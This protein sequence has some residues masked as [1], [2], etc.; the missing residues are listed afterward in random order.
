MKTSWAK[1]TACSSGRL[2]RRFT[3][4]DSSSL[5]AASAI[6]TIVSASL[7]V[8]SR[9]V[10]ERSWPRF[11]RAWCSSR[12]RMKSLIPTGRDY[13]GS[14]ARLQEDLPRH[15]AGALLAGA[16][17]GAPAG[18]APQEQGH[19]CRLL[20]RAVGPLHA[21]LSCGLLPR[22]LQDAVE[23]VGKDAGP[24]VAH[25]RSLDERPVDHGRTERKEG[26]S[27]GVRHAFFQVCSYE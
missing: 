25:E 7:R 1:R 27:E 17:F 9:S 5:M 26:Y 22:S 8:S 4:T 14:G 10:S 18:S 21:G 3:R 2:T 19:L 23:R 15:L 6:P 20:Q 24:G 13:I 12:Q 16:L 11:S